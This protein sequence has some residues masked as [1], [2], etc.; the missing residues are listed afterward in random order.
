[1]TPGLKKHK[2]FS[3]RREKKK[4]ANVKRMTSIILGAATSRATEKLKDREKE[5]VGLTTKRR[6]PGRRGAKRGV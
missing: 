4:R 1:M 3:G 2:G 6:S 5:R